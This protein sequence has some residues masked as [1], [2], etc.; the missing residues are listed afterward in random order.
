MLE[1]IKLMPK[2][3]IRGEVKGKT[4]HVAVS[5]TRGRKRCRD[6]PAPPW[7][8]G[9]GRGKGRQDAVTHVREI[10]SN[11]AAVTRQGNITRY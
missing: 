11:T 9:A 7:E 10:L 4:L 2:R 6:A 3:A 8:A 1:T 5:G